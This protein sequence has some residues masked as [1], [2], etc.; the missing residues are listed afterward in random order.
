MCIEKG[1]LIDLLGDCYLIFSKN[2]IEN[3]LIN[4]LCVL[5]KYYL[6]FVLI[7]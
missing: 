1:D 2:I 5:Y 7:Y 6:G 4:L 3:I